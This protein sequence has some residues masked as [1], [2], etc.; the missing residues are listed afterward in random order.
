MYPPALRG[1]LGGKGSFLAQGPKASKVSV[2][3][4][5]RPGEAR[6]PEGT[7]SGPLGLQFPKA[8]PLVAPRRERNAFPKGAFSLLLSFCDTKRKKEAPRPTPRA[9]PWTRSGGSF[10]DKRRQPFG[11][12][13]PDGPVPGGRTGCPSKTPQWGVFESSGSAG[14]FCGRSLHLGEPHKEKGKK[15]PKGLLFRR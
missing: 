12:E 1:G 7:R 5:Q 13:K 15:Y 10:G 4:F 9:A 14:T 8:A 3:P 6:V 2:K 11:A